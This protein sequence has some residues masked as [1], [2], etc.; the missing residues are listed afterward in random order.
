[1]DN[2][3][4]IRHEVVPGG[5]YQT[6][7]MHEF[8]ITSDNTALITIYEPIPADLSSIGGPAEGY[9]LNSIFQEISIASGEVLFEWSSS[10]HVP[11]NKT[12][13]T[14]AYCREDPNSAFNGCGHHPESAFDYYHLNSIEKDRKGNYLISARNTHTVSYLDGHS[15]EVLWNLGGEDGEFRDLSG[16]AATNF[17]WQHHARWYDFGRSISLFDNGGASTMAGSVESRGMLIDLDLKLR[18]ASLRAS[19]YHPQEMMSLSQGDVQILDDTGNVFIG[20]GRSAA[21][22]EFSIDGEVLCDARFGAS[23]F[24]SFGP[25]TSYRAFRHAWVG[26]PA[27]PPDVAVVDGSV[28]ASWNGA[29]EVVKWQLEGASDDEGFDIISQTFKYGFETEM[30]SP[31]RHHY[32]ILRVV[33]LD[34]EGRVLGVSEEVECIFEEEWI[35]PLAVMIVTFV[36]TILGFSATLVVAAVVWRRRRREGVRYEYELL[37]GPRGILDG[38]SG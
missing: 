8:E 34:G 23:V 2:T 35:T 15:G 6:G 3:Y 10:A 30:K 4:T 12:L 26:E 5:D 14:L 18:T 19:Y 24:F 20:W 1:M 36:A 33:A 7:D 25:I 29:T 22:T 16:G 27:T 32:S 37:A 31:S 11:V 13:W 21:F 17:T 28:Y 38:S 9:L